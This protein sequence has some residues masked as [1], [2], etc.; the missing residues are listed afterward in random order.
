M[1]QS[2]C[3]LQTLSGPHWEGSGAQRGESG[4]VPERLLHTT[5]SVS[6]LLLE[7]SAGWWPCCCFL[8][9]QGKR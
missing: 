9:F 6:V 2:P 5:P 3:P 4:R 1:K 7:D 8:L